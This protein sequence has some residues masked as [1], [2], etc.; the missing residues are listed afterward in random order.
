M[1]SY[2]PLK[3]LLV[4]NDIKMIELTYDKIITSNISVKLNNDSGYVN[5]STIDKIANYLTQRLGRTVSIDEIVE[6][7]PNVSERIGQLQ[8]DDEPDI[9]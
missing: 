6:F 4:D 2:K 8:N 7:V 1:I 9:D 5:L 3:K